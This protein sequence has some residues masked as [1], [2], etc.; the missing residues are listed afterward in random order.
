MLEQFSRMKGGSFGRLDRYL[1]VNAE[2]IQIT[3][4]W[5]ICP[6]N[7]PKYTNNATEKLD[8]L[9]DE[10]VKALHKRRKG[11][12]PMQKDFHLDMDASK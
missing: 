3:D 11:K 6:M 12:I 7:C 5:V 8:K 4:G 9:D 1:G 10:D 2:R